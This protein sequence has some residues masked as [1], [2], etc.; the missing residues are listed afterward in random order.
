MRRKMNVRVGLMLAVLLVG[1]SAASSAEPLS[2]SGGAAIRFL[3]PLERAWSWL[4]SLAE[5]TVAAW[6]GSEEGTKSETVPET[7][8]GLDGGA[9]IDPLGGE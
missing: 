7:L 8:N 3:D 9:F 1:A 6:S 5:E 4:S 2:A